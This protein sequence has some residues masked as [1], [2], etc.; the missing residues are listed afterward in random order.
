[1]FRIDK[2]TRGRFGNKILQYNNLLQ[3]ASQQGVDAS[4]DIWVGHDFFTGLVTNNPTKKQIKNLSWDNILEGEISLLSKEYEYEIGPYCL[5]NIFWKVTKQDPRNFLKIDV[6]WKQDLPDDKASVG[7]HFRGTDILGADGNHGREIHGFEYYKNSIDTVEKEIGNVRYFLCTDDLSFDS[8]KR[9]VNYLEQ[10]GSE[11][12]LGDVNNYF[13]DFSI[14]SECDVLISSSSTFVV[15]AGFLGKPNKKI[16]HSQEWIDKNLNHE[17]WHRKPDPEWVRKMQIS[18]D[19]FW[20]ALY[21]GGNHF[22]KAWRW[23]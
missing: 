20:N 16:I 4:C 6:K 14:L 23:I 2:V 22:Y 12:F 15:C 10:K 17:P 11:F 9:V 1:M 13:F 5:H 8:Y 21:N 7:I 3:I 19:N 18:F